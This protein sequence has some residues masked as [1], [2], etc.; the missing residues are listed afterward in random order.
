MHSFRFENIVFHED[1]FRPLVLR[2]RSLQP[3]VPLR[4]QLSASEPGRK[5]IFSNL[6]RPL[7]Q[8]KKVTI[9]NTFQ[10]ERLT[11]PFRY[12]KIVLI[13]FIG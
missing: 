1:Y 5:T 13:M 7:S 6:K 10:P 2:L 12:N 4:T 3:Y 9:P 8:P 11:P